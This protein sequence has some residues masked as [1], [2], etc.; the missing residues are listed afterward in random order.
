MRWHVAHNTVGRGHVYQGRFKSFPIQEDDHFF[1]A[2]RYVERNAL[3]AGAV[4]RAEA[5]RWGSLWAWRQGS[6]PLKALLSGWPL[7]RPRNWVALVNAPMTERE[8]EG[9]QICLARNRPYGDDRWQET[10]AKRLGLMHTLRSEG[11]PKTIRRNQR[12]KN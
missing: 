12:G 3:T 6:E 1:T 11:R 2:C 7:E 9:L 4:E 5:W 8:A 10:Q